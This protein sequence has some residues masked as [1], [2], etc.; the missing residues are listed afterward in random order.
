M[1]DE[2]NPDRRAFLTTAA[3]ASFMIIKPELVRGSQ[4]NSEVRVGLLG[5]G[6]RGTVDATSIAMNGPARMVALADLF[7][8]RLVTAKKHFDDVAN[9]QRHAGVAASQMFQGPHAAEQIFNSPQVDAVV[10][11][12]PPYFHPQH[13]EMAVAAGKHVYCEKPVGVDV[14]G[15]KRAIEAGKRAEGR[16]SL[17]VGFQIRNAPPFVELVRRIHAGALGEITCGEAHYYCPFLA[18]PDYPKASPAEL[19]L[20]H[21]LHDRVL[22]GDIIVEQNIHVVDICNWVLQGHPVK[23]IGT[24]GR[25]GRTE[26]PGDNWS[27]FDVVFFYPNDVHVSFSSCQFGKSPFEANE[28]F[29]GTRGASRSPYSGPLGIEGDEAWTWAESEKPATT[30]K[31]PAGQFSATGNFSDNLAQAD[32]EKHA[33]FIK[34]IVTRNYHNQAALGA[35]SAMSAMLGRKAAYTGK[36][37]TWDELVKSDEKW[38]AGIDIS[39]MG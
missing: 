17:D 15:A 18:M 35:E 11:A 34:S 32:S 37:A 3:A 14:A 8:D 10:I 7:E 21:W 22:S 5:C 13:L 20:R 28:R 2:R 36:E 23:A 29:F 9:Q 1:T 24:G 26:S 19:R 12:T 30:T 38:D 16:L 6:G 27:H 25:K 39:R 33:A 31:T 4:A